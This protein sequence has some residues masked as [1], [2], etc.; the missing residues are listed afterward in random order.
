[1][2]F[3]FAHFTLDPLTR[4][5]RAN[6]ELVSLPPKNF[7]TL[8]VLLRERH[9][10]V[11]REELLTEVW[12]DEVG[13]LASLNVCI[14]GIRKVLG[15]SGQDQEL[16]RTYRGRGYRF[17]GSVT[18]DGAEREEQTRS[19][20]RPVGPF[21]GR[22]T[23]LA[24]LQTALDRAVLQRRSRLVLV[25]GEAGIGKTTIAQELGRRAG[26]HQATVLTGRC[27]EGG[28]AI[29]YRP[30]SQVLRQLVGHAEARALASL[31]A[32]QLACL[33]QI[34][35]ELGDL[36]SMP[37]PPSQDEDFARLRLFGAVAQ[38]FRRTATRRGS[39]LVLD[40][41]HW[42]DEPSL[43]L[44]QSFV[45]EV[46]DSPLLVVATAREHEIGLDDPRAAR[47]E[48]LRQ[49][50]QCEVLA[51]SGLDPAE[52]RA[53][54]DRPGAE[55]P[56]AFV[57]QVVTSTHGNPFFILE[58]MRHLR[59]QQ[60]VRED[61]PWSAAIAPE[62]LVRIDGLRDL[63]ERR[64]RRLAKPT[65]EALVVAS[66]I[67]REFDFDLLQ[68]ASGVGEGLVDAL[69]EA[70]DAHLVEEQPNEP[71]HYLFAHALTQ[72]ALY[73][74]QSGARRSQN[75][76][77][78]AAAIEAV[79]YKDLTPR[80]SELAHHS[81]AGTIVGAT[82]DSLEKAVDYGRRAGDQAVGRLAYEE[83][84]RHFSQAIRLLEDDRDED[85][86]LRCDL[87]LRLRH[88]QSAAGLAAESEQTALAAAAVADD[89]GSP[90]RLAHAAI[91]DTGG[92][93]QRLVDVAQQTEL[94]ERALERV[95]TG[96]PRLRSL[97]LSRLALALYYD[98]LADRA[99][100]SRLAK[101]AAE[102]ARSCGDGVALY[103]ALVAHHW[104]A[105]G[106][107]ASEPQSDLIDELVQLAT[108]LNDRNLLVRARGYRV[109][110]LL[111]RGDVS[112]VEKEVEAVSE[113]AD[114]VC[115]PLFQWT[116]QTFH[117]AVALARGQVDESER[118]SSE[119]LDM[120]QRSGEDNAFFVYVCQ[121]GAHR[122]ARAKLEELE[123]LMEDLSERIPFPLVS[124]VHAFAA[125]ERGDVE[126][127]RS[128]LDAMRGQ[129]FED[130][131]EDNLWLGTI[132]LLA[133]VAS[134]AG[135]EQACQVLYDKLAPYADGFVTVG[136][137]VVCLGAVRRPL[138]LVAAALGHHKRAE[139]LFSEAVEQERA[140]EMPLWMAHTQYEFAGVLLA[141]GR[142][143]D[144]R[145]AVALLGDAARVADD[146][147]VPSFA[148]VVRAR[149]RRAKIDG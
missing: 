87:L 4:E 10:V 95:G 55:I 24:R 103:W 80:L 66:V 121:T 16:V 20:R 38:L 75:H 74:S 116:T 96:H 81:Y 57:Q 34:A 120:G 59:E 62:D 36:P 60:G 53:L 133:H 72:A 97:L 21:V 68:V 8:V 86:A 146:L 123:S 79:A 119:A 28:G 125:R 39:L 35:P 90:E 92:M 52:V 41:L 132:A 126:L 2:L 58:T 77:H 109:G 84:I 31:P 112:A 113:L 18:A 76:R 78:V 73:E 117:A 82:P 33:A 129:D 131:P 94:I 115:S 99:Q 85:A 7:D 144:L 136:N 13:S 12:R 32:A 102:L 64:L 91:G 140:A 149:Q 46:R 70:A 61:A 42:A 56:E 40:D 83:A 104:S 6:G 135:D 138:A 105:F 5:L 25:T 108:G 71:G 100:R 26:R 11:P 17:V 124:A 130:L 88:A 89:I 54:L 106:P 48:S 65:R 107:G 44:L 147:D 69:D 148:S 145:K 101:E 29:P 111:H 37:Q 19:E 45:E 51:L 67:G 50:P 139:E 137:G 122:L 143:S 43:L 1:M 128:R 23:E 142:K 63:L 93:V 14:N 30:W 114:A 98:A 118:R 49:S 9:R 27:L 110:A 3:Q 141:R 134:F 22:T 127:A 47:L 15:D